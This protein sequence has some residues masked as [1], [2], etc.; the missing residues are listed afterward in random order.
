MVIDVIHL[1]SL[2]AIKNSRLSRSP[3][4]LNKLIPKLSSF[5]L[6]CQLIWQSVELEFNLSVF[7]DQSL[8]L[9]RTDVLWKYDRDISVI[10]LTQIKLDTKELFDVGMVY[11]KAEHKRQS[12]AAP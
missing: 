9:F 1:I 4:V 11:I 6:P 7:S 10:Q 12:S 2:V 3:S 8:K 5:Q